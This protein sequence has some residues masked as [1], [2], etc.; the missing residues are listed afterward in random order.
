MPNRAFFRRA[1]IGLVG[2]LLVAA[3][4]MPLRASAQATTAAGHGTLDVVS[5]TWRVPSQGDADVTA[6][7]AGMAKDGKLSVK[8]TAGAFG[9][10]APGRGRV[11]NLIIVYRINGGEPQTK[12]VRGGGTLLELEAPAPDAAGT[13]TAPANDAIRMLK[14]HTDGIYCMAFSPDGKILASGSPDQSVILW[15]VASGKAIKKID[16]IG[17]TPISIAFSPDGKHVAWGTHDHTIGTWNLAE[18]KIDGAHTQMCPVSALGFLPDSRHFVSCCGDRLRVWDLQK[19][20]NVGVYEAGAGFYALAVST[21]GKVVTIDVQAQ[22]IEW[23][24]IT[25]KQIAHHERPTANTLKGNVDNFPSGLCA[26]ADDH[27]LVSDHTGIWDWDLA[28]DKIALVA[29]QVFT[30][31]G[32]STDG[33]YYFGRDVDARFWVRDAGPSGTLVQPKL[34]ARPH[35]LAVSPDGKYIA[36]S[37]VGTFTADGDW[38]SEAPFDIRLESV[39]PL[40]KQV[41]NEKDRE[42]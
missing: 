31:S 17:S 24:P 6:A 39:A 41:A 1:E 33:K 16:G 20:E 12:T 34:P 21:T 42:A 35:A 8:V 38:H 40:E 2:G 29:Q 15:D 19:T 18:E 11:G 32:V 25:G 3:M 14:G 7:A 9:L 4:L 5:A 26:A 30:I 28:D 27:V 37:A 22:L 13:T 36:I 23:D 10:A